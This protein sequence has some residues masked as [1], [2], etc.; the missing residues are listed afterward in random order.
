M[1]ESKYNFF[2]E[3]E[4]GDGVIL[5][6]SFTSAMAEMD[7]QEFEEFNKSKENSFN[8]L[9]KE[10]I[11]LLKSNGYIIEDDY[12]ELDAI[13]CTFHMAKY[14]NKHMLLTI[15]PTEDC[16]FRCVYCYEKSSIM[17]KYMDKV[18]ADNIVSYV[19]NRVKDIK[20]LSITWYG[21]EPLLSMDII[22]YISEN[23]IKLC[24]ENN[25]DFKASIVTNGY[26]LNKENLETLI[27]CNVKRIQV[28][29]DGNKEIHDKRRFLKGGTPTFDVI[30]NNLKLVKNYDINVNL[31]INVDKGNI[32]EVE[33]ITKIIESINENKNIRCY[34]GMVNSIDGCYKEE[35]CFSTEE[36]SYKNLEFQIKRHKDIS[37]MYP[38]IR[39]LACGAEGIYSLVI[40]AD[41][42]VY[43][44]WED[45]GKEEF[46]LGNINNEINF[47]NK[48]NL[49]FLSNNP[50]RDK[51]CSQCKV[52]P[53]C[54]GGCLKRAKGTDACDMIKF[55]LE[56]VIK[57]I[58]ADGR[59]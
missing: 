36:F 26:L 56:P 27:G 54:M 21:G 18:T 4:N 51:S 7:K 15:A 34:L 38:N 57:K 19:S 41:G 14:S 33:E 10:F 17:P 8:H 47:Y 23:I 44:C 22:K 2:I 49:N 1:K 32:D 24:D 29:I 11:E 9:D 43:K 55:T 16:N 28:T 59:M 53:I 40:G 25:I 46:S 48:N 13:E 39:S 37:Y 35:K 31:R 6:N 42:E 12:S 50:V 3:K 58:Y 52:L 5:Y 30:V 20:A 45:I